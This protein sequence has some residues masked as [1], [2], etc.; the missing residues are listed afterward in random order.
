M[1]TCVVI[2]IFKFPLIEA[3]RPRS[4]DVKMILCLCRVVT[5]K[6]IKAAIADGAASVDEVAARTQ[7]G[8]GCGACREEVHALLDEEGI[9]C[10]GGACADCPRRRFAL[11]APY[12]SL[13]VE[14]P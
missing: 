10:E 2:T 13:P 9:T 4:V 3:R 14:A 12:G 8:T 5:A 7:A 11:D 1:Y 6:S